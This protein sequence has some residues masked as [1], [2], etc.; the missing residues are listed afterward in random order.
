MQAVEFMKFVSGALKLQAIFAA[1]QTSHRS[2]LIAIA[3]PFV[4]L[5]LRK[6]F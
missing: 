2:N 6:S 5:Q 4:K 1:A 3:S